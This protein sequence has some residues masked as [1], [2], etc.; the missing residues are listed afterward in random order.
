MCMHLRSENV[1]H[2]YA[3]FFFLDYVIKCIYRYTMYKDIL[4][5]IH[6]YGPK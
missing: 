5:H 1:V 3:F 2:G 4:P 6:K